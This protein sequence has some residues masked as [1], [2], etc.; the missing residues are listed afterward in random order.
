MESVHLHNTLNGASSKVTPNTAQSLRYRKLHK[1]G[2]IYTV[3][4]RVPSLVEKKELII[5]CELWLQR[6]K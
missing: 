3:D 2:Q 1:D 5:F 4:E 6:V